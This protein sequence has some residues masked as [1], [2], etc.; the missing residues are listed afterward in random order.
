MIELHPRMPVILPRHLIPSALVV[1]LALIG[2]SI[3]PVSE[4]PADTDGPQFACWL[5]DHG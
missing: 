1:V 3:A 2:P 5:R 4:C